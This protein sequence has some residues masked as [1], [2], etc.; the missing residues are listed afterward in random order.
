MFLTEEY[1][2]R[3]AKKIYAKTIL[4]VFAMFLFATMVT[5]QTTE[6]TYQGS[7]KDGA[8]SANGSYDFEFRLYDAVS[9]GVQ[10][11]PT[12]SRN[13]TA[14]AAGS[15][16]TNLDFGNGFPGADR[17]LEIGLRPVGGGGFTLLTP[18]QRISSAPYAFKAMI[19]QT[20][21]GA[22]NAATATN[23]LQLGGVAAN[24]FVLTG[25]ARLSDARPPTPGS[26]SYIQNQN[27]GAQA[28]SNFNISGNGVI[29]GNLTI[30]GGLTANLPAGDSSYVQNRT[31]TQSGS[32]FNISG[33][34]TANI[35][36]ATQFNGGNFTGALYNGSVFNSTNG[37]FQDNVRILNTPGTNNTFAGRL[38]GTANSGTDNSFFGFNAGNNNTSAA[39]NAF[40]GSEAGSL[41]TTGAVNTFLGSA[42]GKN[43]IL[44]SEN[45]FIGTSAGFTNSGGNE[46]TFVG[47]SAGRLNVNGVGNTF[48]GFEAG[49]INTASYN[50][51]FGHLSGD[52]NTTGSS[53]SFF[54]KSSGG[55]NLDGLGNSFFGNNAGFGNTS[56]NN[57]SFFGN[58]AGDLNTTGSNNTFVGV[59]AGNSYSNGSNNT[60]IGSGADMSSSGLSFATAI[61][62]GAAVGTSNTLVIGR[63]ADTVRIPGDVRL[64]NIGFLS[65]TSYAYVCVSDTG[66]LFKCPSNLPSS[67]NVCTT[68]GSGPLDSGDRLARCAFSGGVI[69]SNPIKKVID[70]AKPDS[71]DVVLANAVNGQQTQIDDQRKQLAEQQQLIGELKALVCAANSAAPICRSKE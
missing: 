3:S 9:G 51:F 67:I 46:N 59:D 30:S 45:T 57:N 69:P 37:F 60:A 27:A 22:T 21:V 29:G 41:N 70:D 32:N 39:N 14:V 7:L 58:G 18:R 44:G 52:A 56:G 6:F 50:T 53:N 43:N 23:S 24:Q 13:G 71:N 42:A 17:Y 40:F 1:F 11:G 20:A 12:L 26:T 36:A 47:R 54:G 28:A 49:R 25:D 16:S 31:S 15:F 68:G 5:G 34:G 61:G 38:S 19:A 8:S 2:G 63:A 65:P 4:S 48:V 64:P 62:A 10:I 55:A 33:T 66:L 35:F